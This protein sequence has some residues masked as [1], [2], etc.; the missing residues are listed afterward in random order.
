MFFFFLVSY[1]V[2]WFYET[3]EYEQIFSFWRKL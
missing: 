2:K 3:I 1:S